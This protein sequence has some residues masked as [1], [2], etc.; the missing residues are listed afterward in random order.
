MRFNAHA[1]QTTEVHVFCAITP[2]NILKTNKHNH[3]GSLFHEC[4]VI[5]VNVLLL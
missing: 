5:I 4:N 1:F 2:N 3:S